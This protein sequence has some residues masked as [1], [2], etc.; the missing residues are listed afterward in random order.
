MNWTGGSRARNNR[1]SSNTTRLQKRYF[2]KV[3]AAQASI[4]FSHAGSPFDFGDEGAS[5]GG[6]RRGARIPDLDIIVPRGRNQLGEVLKKRKLFG[7]PGELPLI[8]GS[9]QLRTATQ[10][11]C[12]QGSGDEKQGNELKTKKQLLLEKDDWVCTTLSRPLVLKRTATRRTGSSN[13]RETV[14]DPVGPG[15][16]GPHALSFTGYPSLERRS[17]EYVDTEEGGSS[18]FGNRAF[19]NLS[20]GGYVQIGGSTQSELNGKNPPGREMSHISEETMLFDLDGPQEYGSPSRPSP[21]RSIPTR[22]SNPFGRDHRIASPRVDLGKKE[23]YLGGYANWDPVRHGAVKDGFPSSPLTPYSFNINDLKLPPHRDYFSGESPEQLGLIEEI[24][25]AAADVLSSSPSTILSTI[26]IRPE[27]VPSPLLGTS[28]QPI[29]NTQ[30]RAEHQDKLR[31]RYPTHV[32]KAI[33]QP[34]RQKILD[35]K[36]LEEEI[37][38]TQNPSLIAYASSGSSS[39]NGDE[40]D[41][42]MLGSHL[43]PELCRGYE[44]INSAPSAES[45]GNWGALFK[46]GIGD[47][48]DSMEIRHGERR[49]DAEKYL[50]EVGIWEKHPGNIDEE[51]VEDHSDASESE[52][53]IGPYE[54]ADDIAQATRKPGTKETDDE[55]AQNT[56]LSN[57]FPC[58]GKKDEGEPW[59]DFVI[60]PLNSFDDTQKGAIGGEFVSRKLEAVDSRGDSPVVNHQ[61][62][63]RLGVF[64]WKVSII[65]KEILTD[66]IRT[67]RVPSYE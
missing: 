27:S 42:W 2:A 11:S 31:Y 13:H 46:T 12:L 67:S 48:D 33:V 23:Y 22:D 5:V 25:E 40:N 3:R 18:R 21:V 44:T 1:S 14:Q 63:E 26:H 24:E 19:R 59:R 43:P 20:D 7:T 15:G 8:E 6:K 29:D 52:D 38:I 28:L 47:G 65:Q 45:P 53:D 56:T 62:G 37:E 4:P 9:S 30:G 58:P 54:Q 57:P 35:L 32:E 51:L 41:N 39:S 50:E 34:S 10:T 16:A 61:I 49:Y 36:E 66:S 55:R 17:V 64:S 60:G